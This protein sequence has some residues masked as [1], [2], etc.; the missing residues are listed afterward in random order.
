MSWKILCSILLI[1]VISTCNIIAQDL[2]QIGKA[3][4]FSY[5]GGISANTIFYEGTGLRDPFTYVVNG[6]VNFNISGIYNIP[7]SFAYSNQNFTTNQ[8]FQFNRLSLHP[9]YKWITAHIGDVSMSFSPYTLSGHQFTGLGVDLT[10]RG[11]FKISA[12]YGRFI[13][14]VEY[15]S[16]IPE[17][18]PTYKRIGY[19]LKTQYELNKGSV[20]LIVL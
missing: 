10:P 8:P 20:G 5:S 9:S 12:M 18:I 16:T 3:S 13:K 7:V 19:G 4:L 15:E 1:N 17:N 14:P 6:N 2:T 11:K